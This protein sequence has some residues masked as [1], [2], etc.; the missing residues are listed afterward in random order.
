MDND[1]QIARST[2]PR[3]R[4]RRLRRALALTLTAACA[5][6]AAFAVAPPPDIDDDPTR[7]STAL[8]AEPTLEWI[9]ADSPDVA[10]YPGLSSFLAEHGSDWE[11]VLDRRAGR[12]HLLQGPG[13]ALVPG[14]GNT[15][16]AKALGL[17]GEP[18]AADVERQLRQLL[19][20]HPDLLAD[21]LDA[22][23][24]DEVRSFHIGD[25]W[26]I[27]LVQTHGGVEVENARILARLTAGNLTQLAAV[28]VA[29]VGIAAEPALS[30]DDAFA[31]ASV[32]ASPSSA[33]AAAKA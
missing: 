6:Q 15:L 12:P 18:R 27:E 9:D 28:R 4:A 17:R 32:G 19:D 7:Q 10:R 5:A 31:V 24:L 25:H 13:V 3:R 21:D 22:F 30:A 8:V 29:P 14:A 26:S 16:T 11:I 20:R 33:R 1:P 23:T 2:P